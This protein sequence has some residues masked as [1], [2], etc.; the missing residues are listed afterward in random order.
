[1]LRRLPH[2][3]TNLTAQDGDV[4]TKRYLGPH[5]KQRLQRD[6][7]CLRSFAG[8][9]PVPSLRSVDEEAL[10]I[11]LGLVDGVHGQ[12][13]L[14]PAQ[15]ERVL[16]ATGELAHALLSIKPPDD[17]EFENSSG[18]TFV[19]GDFG[20]QN[21]LVDPATW[22][23][24]AL[25]DFEFAHIGGPLED[26]SWSEW[27]VRTHHPRATGYLGS[28]FAGF[29]TT[30]PWPER[31]QLMEENCEAFISRATRDGDSAGFATWTARL[32]ATRRGMDVPS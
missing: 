21:L 4:V 1:M 30:P 7:V 19:H 9:L 12:D 11:T 14:G 20:A 31:Q 23:V 15:A 13:A 25:L 18:S 10:T 16:R 17:E 27:I 28:L 32:G 29:G 22:Q 6:V 2:G 26:V 5:A 3:Y 24:I 8:K